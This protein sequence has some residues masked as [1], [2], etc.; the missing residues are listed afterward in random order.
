MEQVSEAQFQSQVLE[1]ELLVVVDFYAEWCAPCKAI[2]PTLEELEKT[3]AGQVR[4]V[5]VDI[6]DDAVLAETHGVT[7]VPTLIVFKNGAAVDRRTG[8]ASKSA[9]TTWLKRHV[10][11]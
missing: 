10:G 11:S 4:F 5:K 2:A 8:G 1:S 3:H 6:D 7:T 9:L